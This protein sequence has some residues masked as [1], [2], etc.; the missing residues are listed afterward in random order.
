MDLQS[1]ELFTIEPDQLDTFLALG[2]F[3][4]QQTIFTT[5]ILYFHG[6]PYNA[7]W[8]RVHLTTL[9]LDRKCSSLIVKNRNFRTEISIATITKQHEILYAEYKKSIVFDAAPTLQWILIGN[10]KHN[11]FNTYAI[12]VYDGTDLI[13]AGFFDIGNKSAAGIISIYDPK[14]KKYSLGKYIICKKM[15]YCSDLH[16]DYFYPGY[17]VPGYPMF[18]YKLELGTSSLEYFD[19]YN[20]KWLPL[21]DIRA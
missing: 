14:Y 17:F 7:V 19:D 2:W 9:A 16:L 5:N 6:L 15:L 8:L 12:N 21:S 18:D 10:S 11:V 3:R 20:T 4:M 13:A 1:I